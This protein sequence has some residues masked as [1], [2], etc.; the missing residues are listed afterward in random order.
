VIRYDIDR[1]EPVM[2]IEDYGEWCK[3]EEVQSQLRLLAEMML[4]H[5]GDCEHMDYNEKQ[6]VIEQ[7]GCP[8]CKLARE[9]LEVG[10]DKTQKR[11]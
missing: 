3:Y 9:I 8:A 7:C 11:D 4:E 5:H 6:I 10:N 1:C 2:N